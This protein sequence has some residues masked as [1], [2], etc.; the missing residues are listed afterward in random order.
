[1][2]LLLFCQRSCISRGHD[3]CLDAINSYMDVRVEPDN[4][5]DKDA[6]FV[7]GKRKRISQK[8]IQELL[9]KY[10]K[11][12]DLTGKKYTAHKLRHT[13]A[14][15]LYKH[16]GVDIRV[17]QQILGHESVSTTQIYTHVDAEQ[18]RDAVKLNPLADLS[19]K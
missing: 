17:L 6:L 18:L 15:L 14:T 11:Q 2:P 8:A 13:A 10:F 9:G 12:A 19:K 16:G 5:D 4:E 7:S 1:M 3:L